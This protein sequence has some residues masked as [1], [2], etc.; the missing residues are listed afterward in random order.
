MFKQL[1]FQYNFGQKCSR[2]LSGCKHI[3][4]LKLQQLFKENRLSTLNCPT[5]KNKSDEQ[6]ADVSHPVNKK[7]QKQNKQ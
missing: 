2:K 1:F 7:Q 3:K 5:L 4:W 6:F